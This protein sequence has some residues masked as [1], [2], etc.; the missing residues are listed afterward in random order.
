MTTPLLV[1]DVAGLTPR[2]LPHTPNLRALAQAGSPAQ[3]PR[4][5]R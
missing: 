5:T 1:I 4:L 3:A 2:L